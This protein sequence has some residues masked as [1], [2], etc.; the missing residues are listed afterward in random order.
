[1]FIM[2]TAGHIDHGKTTLITS[3]SGINPDRLQEE[4]TRGMTVDLGFAWFSLPKG[5][6][7]VIDVPGHHR[8]VKNMLAGVGRLDFVLLV[9][10][11]DDGWMP[12]TQEHVEILHLYGVKRGLVAL[13]KTDLVDDDWLELVTADIEEHLMGTSL[14]D[15]PIIPVSAVSGHNLDLLKVKMNE[16]LGRLPQTETG[17]N[18]LLWIDRVFSIKGAGTVCTGSLLGGSLEVGMD[19]VVEPQGYKGR[20]RGLQTQT[21]AV[22]KGLP[23]SRLAV[24]LTGVERA[25]LTRGMYIALP[26]KRPYVSLL[27]AHVE[28]LPQAP[29]PL[30]TG[31]EVKLYVGTLETLAQVKVLGLKEL[32]PG[33]AGFV[34]LELEQPAHFS[35]KD[36]FILRHSEL[37]AT[38]GGGSF[39]EEGI[40]V[41]GLN[42][43]LVGP[44]RL[45]QR[46][47]FE[48]P[49][50]Y[51]D[52]NRLM[53]KFNASPETLGLFKAAERTFWTKSEFLREDS[54]LHPDLIELGDFILA[55]EHFQKLQHYVE[56]KVEAFHHANPLALGLSKETLRSEVGVP[57]RLFDQI[58]SNTPSVVE[59]RGAIR[60]TKHQIRL[61]D[62]EEEALQNL[63]AFVEAKRFEPPTLTTLLEQGFTR[64]L[65]FA[66]NHLGRLV[67]LPDEHWSSPLVLAE[68]LSFL[69]DEPEFK[70]GFDLAAFRDRLK[71]SRKFSLV[72]LEYLDN[73]G[74]TIRKGDVRILGKRPLS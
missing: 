53:A 2:G 24:N 67:A 45:Q 38:L 71:T 30:A 73:Q 26:N 18:P 52:L 65:A 19:V 42:L 31:Q 34:Q 29:S 61:A 64:E 7:G 17:D 8:L 69:F 54:Q 9:I 68:I 27:N 74:T 6:V 59:V 23:H 20:I 50:S 11:A 39:I 37:Q 13:T 43:R 15:F 10:A 46:F 35:F 32:P 36:R 63:I 48:K 55:P 58:L 49:E 21:T 51:L 44:N 47:P 33:Q 25:E 4:K 5:N 41:R 70:G 14:A 66:G 16:L 60:G 12:Q 56:T 28:L 22:D 3:L 72:F 40:P 62:H 1:M 57:S